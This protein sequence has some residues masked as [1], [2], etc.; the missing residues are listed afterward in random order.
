MRRLSEDIKVDVAIS[1]VQATS[2]QTSRYFK[3]DKYDRAMFVVNI[4]PVGDSAVVSTS[5]LTLMQATDASAATSAV[6]ITG[7]TAIISLGTKVT[8]F[9]ITPDTISADDTFSITGYDING[10]AKTALTFTAADGGSAGAT[11]ADREFS[12]NDTAAGTG[13]VSNACTQIAAI[14]NNTSYG[15]PG[16]YA[17]ASSTQVTCRAIEVGENMFTLT[18]SSTS[19]LAMGSTKVIGICEIN[20]SSLTISSDFT[21]V[22]VNVN[23][24]ISAYTS[25]ICIRK[26]RKRHMPVQ[27]VGAIDTV[28]E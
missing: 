21:H 9:Q 8:E 18:S 20:A 12:V 2:S 7:S 26:G 28:G 27:M 10:D 17:S 5:I 11:A 25:A 16:L 14:L 3:L 15:V 22:A 6:A 23:N 1:P 24:Q 19:N 4:T 13:I